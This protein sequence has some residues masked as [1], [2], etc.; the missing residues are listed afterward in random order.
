MKRRENNGAWDWISRFSTALAVILLLLGVSTPSKTTRLILSILFLGIILGSGI[1]V[2]LNRYRDPLGRSFA[3]DA[4]T[5]QSNTSL[6]GGVQISDAILDSDV[7]RAAQFDNSFFPEDAFVSSLLL[8]MSRR[9]PPG[10]S[11][12]TDASNKVIS[13]MGLWPISKKA[14]ESLKEGR[15]DELEITH[16]DII[17][18]SPLRFWWLGM[19][20]TDSDARKR[21][22]FLTA[23][24]LNYGLEKWKRDCASDVTSGLIASGFT[25]G[26][27]RVANR[28]GMA[29]LEGKSH[30][31]FFIEG[32]SDQIDNRFKQAFP[33]LT[34][35]HH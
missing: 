13:L 21:N 12:A 20:A 3:D 9:Y 18:R 6:T 29:R 2:L 4:T 27:S 16:A 11:M 19:I 32:T 7:T 34:R 31:I 10:I 33:F 22:P 28:L 25:V 14:Y 24:V 5:Q 8:R 35:D 26:G 15:I 17:S 23:H 30:D 1:R